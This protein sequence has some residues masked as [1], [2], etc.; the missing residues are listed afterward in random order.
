MGTIAAFIVPMCLVLLVSGVEFTVHAC[1]VWC[2][3]TTMYCTLCHSSHQ[4]V[5]AILTVFIMRSLYKFYRGVRG[6]YNVQNDD[7]KAKDLVK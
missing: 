7:T 2:V 6:E 4:Q 1:T 5:N 3:H